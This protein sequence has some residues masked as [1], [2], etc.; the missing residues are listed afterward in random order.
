METAPPAD[1]VEWAERWR[2]FGDIF[3][4]A[5]VE[6]GGA[7]AVRF[8]HELLFC[9]LGGHGITY[10]LALSASR[11]LAPI[12]VFS[13]QR[14]DHDLATRVRHELMQ[15]QF[16]PRRQDG[17]LR[18]YRFPDSKSRLITSARTWVRAAHPVQTL[19]SMR[20]QREHRDFLCGCP[21]VGPKTASWL[22][23]NLGLGDELAIIDVHV[24]RALTGTNRIGSVRLP[25]DYE[26]IEKAFLAWCAELGAS[27]PAFD[28]FVW[29]AQRGVN[30]ASYA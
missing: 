17:S 23:R 9:L 29:E 1:N 13:D 11:V 15:P 24:L 3:E 27:P 21:G 19:R 22:L 6:M 30:T 4:R 12:K 18:R 2:V 5:A 26:L 25:R 8:E 16:E 28:L 10:E 14:S 20:T 7:S